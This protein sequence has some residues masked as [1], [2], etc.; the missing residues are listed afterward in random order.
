MNPALTM[1][2]QILALAKSGFY[3][4]KWTAHFHPFLNRKSLTT[5]VQVLI[6]S[7]IDYYNIYMGL[8]LKVIQQV[9]SGW[10]LELFSM[11]IYVLAWPVC[12]SC[13]YA[14]GPN[15]RCL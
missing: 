7:K 5:L 12:T 4:L 8:P 11:T 10:S 13:L 3:Q 14:S 2:Y 6:I 9:L 15:S 1:A